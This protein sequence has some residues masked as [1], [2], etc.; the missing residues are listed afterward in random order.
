MPASLGRISLNVRPLCTGVISAL[1]SLAGSRQDL[2][3]PF[4]FILG[5]STKLL[6]HSYYSSMPRDANICCCYDVSS[7]SLRGSWSAYTTLLGGTW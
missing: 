4:I 6:N 1:S 2:S 5:T 7:F 3:L